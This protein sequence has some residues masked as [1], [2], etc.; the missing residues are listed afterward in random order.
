MESINNLQVNTNNCPYCH[1]PIVAGS[2]VC[3]HCL[4]NLQ[5][6]KSIH[7]KI[8]G[9]EILLIIYMLLLFSSLFAGSLKFTQAAILRY[10]LFHSGFR[11]HTELQ[12]EA[13]TE[14]DLPAAQPTVASQVCIHW[15]EIESYPLGERVC[16]NGIVFDAR[17]NS[18]GN[19]VIRFEGGG[20]SSPILVDDERSYNH[21]EGDCIQAIG[22]VISW[23]GLM[24]VELNGDIQNVK[25]SKCE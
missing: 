24:A 11:M 8:Q 14:S 12:H 22:D 25:K 21:S 9:Q 23:N 7:L 3:G 15:N 20:V 6:R 5:I 10:K 4:N 17:K 2:F 18:S 13:V 1:Q 19:F 16:V